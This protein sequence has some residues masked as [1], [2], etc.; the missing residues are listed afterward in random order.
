MLKIIKII[1]NKVTKM[2]LEGVNANRSAYWLTSTNP[3]ST[4]SPTNKTQGIGSIM[5]NPVGNTY[6]ASEVSPKIPI[7]TAGT[8]IL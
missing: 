4:F 1:S 5:H 2:D 3:V 8:R 7:G 6:D